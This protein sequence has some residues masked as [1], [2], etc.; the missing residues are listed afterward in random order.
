MEVCACG[1]CAPDT[2]LLKLNGTRCNL[3]CAYC[4]EIVKRRL[5]HMSLDIIREL[6]LSLSA[7]VDVIL[8]GGEPLLDLKLAK[9]VIDLHYELRGKRVGIQTNGYCSLHTLE[10]LSAVSEKIKLGVSIDG[11]EHCN[12]Y[13]RTATGLPAFPAIARFLEYAKNSNISVKCISTINNVNVGCPIEVLDYFAS[14]EAVTSLRLNPCFDV[15]GNGLAKYAV[16]PRSFL[17]FVKSATQYWFDSQ[18]YRKFKL[19]PVLGALQ[20]QIPLEEVNSK[21]PCAK[22]VSLYPNEVCTLCDVLGNEPVKRGIGDLFVLHE[23]EDGARECS[24]CANRMRC[25]GCPGIL[26]RFA[27]NNELKAEYCEYR[28]GYWAFISRLKAALHFNNG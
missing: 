27:K 24:S 8:H 6:F 9:E 19:E 14:Q 2:V 5:G 10:M 3:S 17:E 1:A 4:S 23:G 18:Y 7:D 21:L 16:R 11:P 13:R 25:S 12:V 20:S 22:Y 15:S 28:M 26:R